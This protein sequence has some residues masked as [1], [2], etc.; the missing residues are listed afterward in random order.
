MSNIPLIICIRNTTDW[1][2]INEDA[3]VYPCGIWINPERDIEFGKRVWHQNTKKSYCEVRSKLKS[4][5]IQN[6]SS[7]PEL[8]FILDIT[9]VSLGLLTEFLGKSFDN[10]F[11]L[12][13][14]DDDWFN[15]DIYKFLKLHA[16]KKCI[17]WPGNRYTTVDNGF[18]NKVTDTRN[19]R[20]PES[21][22]Y[23]FTKF[24]MEHLTEEQKNTVI[25]NHCTFYDVC[26]K[27]DIC[28]FF[29]DEPLSIYNLHCASISYLVNCKSKPFKRQAMP[30]L[31]KKLLWAYPYIER[32]NGIFNELV[33]ND[34]ISLI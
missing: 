21:N 11:L 32:L 19:D 14:D 6:W 33:K 7:I 34:K 10:Y 4:L 29:L 31:S 23:V 26:E 8:T 1:G 9:N 24:G 20:Y 15:P 12:P 18:L 5:A 30:Q 3:L 2:N 25:K 28:P 13:T 27:S 22:T 17:R 16:N